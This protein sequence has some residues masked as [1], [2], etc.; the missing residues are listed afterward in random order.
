VLNEPNIGDSSMLSSILTAVVATIATVGIAALLARSL[1]RA[2]PSVFEAAA[3][4]IE[5]EKVSAW[6]TVLVGGAISSA[7]LAMALSGKAGWGDLVLTVL[8]LCIAGFMAPSLTSIHMVRWEDDAIEGPSSLFGPTLGLR[9][10]KI[11]WNEIARTG[12]T[13]TAYWFVEAQDGRRVYWS[14][15]YKGYGALSELIRLKRPDLTLPPG[16]LG[17]KSKR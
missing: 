16:M 3:G 7:G 11:R 14:F 1:R 9:R 15:L 2:N 8:G 6:I 4:T 17:Q 10:T 12:V 13:A 5:P